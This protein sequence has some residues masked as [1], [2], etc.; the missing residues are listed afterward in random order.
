MTFFYNDTATTEIYTLTNTLT[1]HD[2]LPITGDQTGN[3]TGGQTGGN[4]TGAQAYSITATVMCV[5]EAMNKT[6][7]AQA[8]NMTENM[9]GNQ[10][11]SM[12][13]NQTGM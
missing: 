8:G 4:M 11:E 5:P 9:T 7:G 2:A 1:L 6:T 3:M 13:G 10:T 12:A